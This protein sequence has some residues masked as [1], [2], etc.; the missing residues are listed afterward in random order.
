MVSKAVFTVALLS[1]LIYYEPKEKA[2]AFCIQ[3]QKHGKTKGA[4]TWYWSKRLLLLSLFRL[5][6]RHIAPCTSTESQQ[7]YN[8]ESRYKINNLKCL[9]YVWSLV[10][11]LLCKVQTVRPCNQK[12][13][14]L[15]NWIV[16]G[17]GSRVTGK[18]WGQCNPYSVILLISTLH[19]VADGLLPAQLLCYKHCGD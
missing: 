4:S 16:H 8:Q 19:T 7:R 12:Q 3:S 10:I 5:P 2:E 18:Q 13:V 1:N 17:H 9:W 11:E 14:G 6:V 15:T